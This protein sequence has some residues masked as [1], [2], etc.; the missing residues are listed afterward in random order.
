VAALHATGF[1]QEDED[2]GLL[3]WA[4]SLRAFSRFD[5]EAESSSV[6]SSRAPTPETGDPADNQLAIRSNDSDNI[7]SPD[8]NYQEAEETNDG[9]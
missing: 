8:Q 2:S 4:Q 1:E 3:A 6:A 5:I 9:R 7:P